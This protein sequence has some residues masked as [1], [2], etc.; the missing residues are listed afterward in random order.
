MSATDWDEMRADHALQCE[1]DMARAE[2]ARAE[3]LGFV[4]RKFTYLSQP[5]DFQSVHPSR[6]PAA[7]PEDDL[8]PSPDAHAADPP[9]QAGVHPVFAR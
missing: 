7:Y 2:A 6:T 9:A 8:A 3:E 5:L 1:E 4:E